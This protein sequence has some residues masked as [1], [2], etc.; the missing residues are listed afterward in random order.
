MSMYL[1]VDE[2]M[3]RD[4]PFAALLI[5][6]GKT[7]VIRTPILYSNQAVSLENLLPSTFH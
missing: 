3:H 7:N 4:L 1:Y 5:A 2:A 6:N